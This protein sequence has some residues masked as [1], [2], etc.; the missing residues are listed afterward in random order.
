MTAT[1][2]RNGAGSGER[3][4]RNP[5][6]PLAA[7]RA[8]LALARSGGTDFRQAAIFMHAT[9]GRSGQR[10]FARFRNSPAGQR[11]LLERPPLRGVLGSTGVALAELPPGTLGQEFD[12]FIGVHGFSVEGMAELGE[13]GVQR[14]VPEDER[15]FA[16][17]MNTLHDVRHVVAGYGAGPLGEL[18]LLAFRFAQCRHPGMACFAVAWTLRMS[19]AAPGWPIRQAVL[20]AYRRGRTAAWL[21]DL[22]WE[23]LLAEPLATLRE[24]L[25]LLPPATYNRILLADPREDRLLWPSS[26]AGLDH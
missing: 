23:E 2:G 21:D 16:A 25:G 24:R 18:C 9:E 22:R 11:L 8:L 7:A 15:W 26:D 14:A 4:S 10:N 1:A 6:R 3:R 19:Q 17:R 5:M 12:A 20:E 13:A